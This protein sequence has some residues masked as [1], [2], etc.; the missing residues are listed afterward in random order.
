MGEVSG[1]WDNTGTRPA[2]GPVRK[3]A[4]KL[5]EL[6]TSSKGEMTVPVSIAGAADKGIISYE[7]D[8]RY[9]PS[10]IRPAADAVDLAGTVS[11]GLSMAVNA[12]E[13]GLLKVA[14]YGAF[15]LDKDGVLLNLRFV[16]VGDP[17]STS[18]LRFERILLNDGDP[19]ALVTEGRIEL[20]AAAAN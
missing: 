14:V 12:S 3:P 7:F 8:L 9:D 1:D 13:P 5:P 19:E 6:V 18:T 10:V 2:H 20:S 15:A 16:S 4:V 17:G 11:R